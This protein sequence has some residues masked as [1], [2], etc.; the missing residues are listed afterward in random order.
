MKLSRKARRRRAIVEAIEAALVAT[1]MI[2]TMAL[3]GAA[4]ELICRLMGW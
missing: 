2:G 4:T 3:I 1:A